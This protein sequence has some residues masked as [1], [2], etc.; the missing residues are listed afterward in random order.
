MVLAAI[1]PLFIIALHHAGDAADDEPVLQSGSEPRCWVCWRCCISR[2]HAPGSRLVDPD[3]RQAME[4]YVAGT[5]Q[6][7][8]Q[9]SRVLEQ[10]GDAEGIGKRL[11][12]T[13]EGVAARHPSVSPEE[14]A[15]ATA[16]IAPELE[17]RRQRPREN[18]RRSRRDHD[19]GRRDGRAAARAAAQH[20]LVADRAGRSVHAHA[21]A[22]RGHARRERDWPRCSRWPACSSPGR[23]RSPG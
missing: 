20:R 2:T 3:V 14:L 11:Q 13:A 1:P 5:A 17:R 16:T 21:R 10:P 23:R 9:R 6:H 7:A 12:K 19:H 18:D 4:T 22:R 8:T 15:R